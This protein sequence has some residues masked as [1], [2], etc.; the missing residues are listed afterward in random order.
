MPRSEAIEVAPPKTKEKITPELVASTVKKLEQ[1][2]KDGN[3]EEEV[4]KLSP[5]LIE[6]ALEEAP[7]KSKYEKLPEGQ[8]YVQNN[9]TKEWGVRDIAT[10]S[11]TPLKEDVTTSP[12]EIKK[13]SGLQEKGSSSKSPLQLLTP[14]EASASTKLLPEKK[15][16]ETIGQIKGWKIGRID[17]N[18]KIDKGEGWQDPTNTEYRE[19]NAVVQNKN[20]KE[21]IPQGILKA[22]T[23]K[24]LK[25]GKK[26][27]Q[28]YV[29]DSKSLRWRRPTTDEFVIISRGS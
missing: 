16:I 14:K 23:I 20:R 10:G 13:Q 21:K 11:V 6:K 18:Y 2:Y 29:R 9:R 1:A 26:G 27:D 8:E 25:V 24:G 22:G 3:L 7:P 17:N 15:P 12:K 19:I 5:E 28:Y 4:S